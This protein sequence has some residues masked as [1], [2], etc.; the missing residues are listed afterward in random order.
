MIRW[1]LLLFFALACFNRAYGATAE[2]L[3]R[4]SAV[5]DRL[6]A[7]Q[8]LEPNCYGVATVLTRKRADAWTDGRWIAVTSAMLAYTD[9]NELAF[10]IAHEMGH[11]AGAKGERAA[12]AS[13]VR[14]TR[15]AGYDP[16]AGASLLRR[17]NSPW[18]AFLSVQ[19]F[20]PTLGQ[21]ATA[22]DRQSI[23]LAAN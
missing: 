1:P 8:H 16:L 20:Q 12:D 4:V 2:Q 15:A 6:C 21:R 13:A 22:I 9:D 17:M 18:R 10:I 11:N 7:G 14:F 19:A 23:R 5:A 3:G